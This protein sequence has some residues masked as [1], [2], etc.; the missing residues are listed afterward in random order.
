MN[1]ETN[2][3]HNI[4]DKQLD[5]EQLKAM[6]VLVDALEDINNANIDAVFFEEYSDHKKFNVCFDWDTKNIIENVLKAFKGSGLDTSDLDTIPNCD[7]Y[8]N[9]D[10]FDRDSEGLRKHYEYNYENFVSA[11]KSNVIGLIDEWKLSVNK[12]IEKFNEYYRG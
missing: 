3:I 10:W 5:K 2:I 4:L 9:V 6:Q 11:E 8:F 7:I 12:F 1:I